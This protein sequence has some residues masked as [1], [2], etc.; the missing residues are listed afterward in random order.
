MSFY[1]EGL[2]PE[3]LKP[4]WDMWN[5]MPASSLKILVSLALDLDPLKHYKDY[6]QKLIK[7]EGYLECRPDN[8]ANKYFDYDREPEEL[9][10]IY[11]LEE[12]SKLSNKD[13]NDIE[14]SNSLIDGYKKAQEEFDRSNINLFK[15][16]FSHLEHGILNSSIEIFEIKNKIK[17]SLIDSQASSI[18]ICDFV[19]WLNNQN[20]PYP[21]QLK[22][23]MRIPKTLRKEGL[24]ELTTAEK[25]KLT[26]ENNTLRRL[27]NDLVKL[28]FKDQ[29][30]SPYEIAKHINADPKTIGRYLKK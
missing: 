11:C 30:P 5:R 10:E 20:I 25:S 19:D 26:Q 17:E 13:K 24:K 7:K 3:E 12:E 1:E 8:R 23:C 15:L 6:Y 21:E 29:D 28:H 18:Y 22:D 4:D 14:V 27:F 16:A 9:Y 2:V